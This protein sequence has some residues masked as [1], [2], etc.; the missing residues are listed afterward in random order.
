MD[1]THS[2]FDN[3]EGLVF[4]ETNVT[5]E[6][7]NPPVQNFEPVYE[8]PVLFS[9]QEYAPYVQHLPVYSPG[10]G[11]NITENKISLAPLTPS[12]AGNFHNA[13]IIV[14]PYGTIISATHGTETS[15]KSV[16]C[17]SPL[18]GG[19]ILENGVIG[20]QK[21]GITNEYLADAPSSL[22][23]GTY[24]SADITVNQKGLLVSAKNGSVVKR[25]DVGSGL[26]KQQIGNGI[27]TLSISEDYLNSLISDSVEKAVQKELQKIIESLKL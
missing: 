7:A 20:L 1:Y 19:V 6:I 14:S 13:N 12:P 27:F 24:S 8:T 18:T 3:V 17:M 11:I 9:L 10:S 2:L 25:I 21:E 4:R 15:V 26:L 23:P 22:T 16:T 5:R